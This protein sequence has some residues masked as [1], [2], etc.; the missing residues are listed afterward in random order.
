MGILVNQIAESFAGTPL[1]W[2]ADML[3]PTCKLAFGIY[4][5]CRPSPYFLETKTNSN[6]LVNKQL[7]FFPV[8]IK[9]SKPLMV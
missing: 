6:T 9:T 2:A 4:L 7:N 3:M 5:T 8:L 1:N